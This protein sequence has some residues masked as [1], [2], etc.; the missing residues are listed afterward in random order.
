MR[1]GFSPSAVTEVTDLPLQTVF[2]LIS[3]LSYPLNRNIL[4][5]LFGYSRTPGITSW[6]CCA[7][8]SGHVVRWVLFT[9]IL[10]F[11]FS[12]NSNICLFVK[13][14]RKKDKRYP[15]LTSSIDGEILLWNIWPLSIIMSWVTVEFGWQRIMALSCPKAHPAIILL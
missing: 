11:A 4:C 8:S 12:L 13:C 2:V 10:R 7:L 5:T 9:F 15:T 3:V 6:Q 14:Q 1:Y